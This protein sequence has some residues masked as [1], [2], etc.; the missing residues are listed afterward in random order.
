MLHQLLILTMALTVNAV[1]D[2]NYRLNTPIVPTSYAITITPYFHNG[3]NDAFT[4][5]GEVTIKFTTNNVTNQIKLHSEDLTYTASNI[6]I[7][8]GTTNIQLNAAEPLSFDDKYTFAFI[9]LQIDLQ[10]GTE[11]TLN[12]MYCG[13]IRDDLSGFYR[14]YYFENGVKK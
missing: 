6:T 9:N 10:P 2:T 11:Y 3:N 5:D 14:S 13:P 8:A 4:F 1:T 7:T 12:I